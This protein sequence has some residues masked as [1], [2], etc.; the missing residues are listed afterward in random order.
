[1]NSPAEGSFAAATTANVLRGPCTVAHS[2]VCAEAIRV[3][4]ALHFLSRNGVD[5][6]AEELQRCH[7]AEALDLA[8]TRSLSN[9]L[10]APPEDAEDTPCLVE[11]RVWSS[12]RGSEVHAEGIGL[13]SSTF[14]KGDGEELAAAAE[15]SFSTP[16]VA[17]GCIEEALRI[18]L[19]TAAHLLRCSA[20]TAV[21][22][23]AAATSE[24]KG[25]G[26][27]SSFVSPSQLSAA[28]QTLP[29]LA[30]AL[31]V[32]RMQE[33]GWCA[34]ALVRF[35]EWL[36]AQSS[37]TS[38]RACLAHAL[39]LTEYERTDPPPQNAAALPTALLSYGNSHRA[40]C[41]LTPADHNR[42]SA[43][44]DRRHVYAKEVFIRDSLP[45]FFPWLRPQQN[46]GSGSVHWEKDDCTCCH[47]WFLEDLPR[48][49]VRVSLD[50][51]AIMWHR[52]RVLRNALLRWC[53]RRGLRVVAYLA[54]ASEHQTDVLEGVG[55][56]LRRE[57]GNQEH[58]EGRPAPSTATLQ[59]VSPAP[60]RRTAK[61]QTVQVEN[62]PTTHQSTAATRQSEGAP[63]RS[64]P[65]PEESDA[66]V[67]VTTTTAAPPLQKGVE[68]QVNAPAPPAA[69]SSERAQVET[70]SQSTTYEVS[71]L[72]RVLQPHNNGKMRDPKEVQHDDCDEAYRTD[73]AV[74]YDPHP[75]LLVDHAEQSSFATPP[76]PLSASVWEP[77]HDTP[78]SALT[79]ST[80]M[81]ESA[82][83]TML[84]ELPEEGKQAQEAQHTAA[85]LQ[86]HNRSRL[87]YAFF[88][89]RD[90]RLYE[91]MATR[92][93]QNQQKAH[94]VR[95]CWSMWRHRCAA[96]SQRRKEA[97]DVALSDVLTEQKA[98]E[99]FRRLIQ[100]WRR[101]ALAQR[102][103]TRTLGSRSFRLWRCE[104]RLMQY[105]RT[106]KQT[107]VGA[108]RVKREVWQRWCDRRMETAADK[109]RASSL[110]KRT[111]TAMQS[112]WEERRTL[113]AA[114][115]YYGNA[116]MVQVWH[117][118][119]SRRSHASELRLISHSVKH[120]ENLRRRSWE[121]WR[122]RMLQREQ[123]RRHESEGY[124]FY[125][126]QKL[127]H[128]FHT[129]VCRYRLE[130]RVRDLVRRHLRAFFLKPAFEKWRLRAEVCGVVRRG[131]EELAW[132]VGEQLKAR[133]VLRVWHRRAIAHA[134]GRKAARAAAAEDEACRLARLHRLA[135]TFY[136]WRT[137]GFLLRRL[138]VDRRRCL[139]AAQRT[140]PL[141]I[142]GNTCA[143]PLTATVRSSV[144]KG[145][146][147]AEQAM[148]TFF[149]AISPPPLPLP[150][151]RSDSSSA[152]RNPSTRVSPR[153]ARSTTAPTSK[154]HVHPSG[155][156]PSQRFT[157]A[158][159]E[160]SPDLRSSSAMAQQQMLL[161]K[162]NS[163]RVAN[164]QAASPHAALA[165]RS[166][167]V[168]I[169]R[170]P[171]SNSRRRTLTLE[172][173]LFAAQ[174][175]SSLSSFGIRLPLELA[176]LTPASTTILRSTLDPSRASTA[177]KQRKLS[178]L[179]PAVHA[180]SSVRS[181]TGGSRGR[182]RHS[183]SPR[184][185]PPPSPSSV[186]SR[187]RSEE[188]SE[189]DA[190]LPIRS[191]TATP[192]FPRQKTQYRSPKALPR[193]S[194]SA[195]DLVES[196][197]DPSPHQL[198]STSVGGGP[199]RESRLRSNFAPR[200]PPN[201]LLSQME[202]LLKRIRDTEADYRLPPAARPGAVWQQ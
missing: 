163:V 26:G 86:Q 91:S 51:Q 74:L 148:K 112:R 73:T 130:S 96:A 71:L 129:W 150:P 37:S 172:R 191:R 85:V 193:T 131:Q 115:K 88:H 114:V 187:T 136:H 123:R 33:P 178:L 65:L 106:S 44:Q 83:E 69:T 77:R 62:E 50:H 25:K 12:H 87:R 155:R 197:P 18:S 182:L 35:T 199:Y 41:L 180:H 29:R 14:I 139:P 143:P 42:T 79:C 128:C 113:R 127:H 137:R 78:A 145:R 192:L 13:S 101:A 166:R 57:N 99:Y 153:A 146:S 6:L 151:H 147:G 185:S 40:R 135:R 49:C 144:S 30:R 11:R 110:L 167:A 119:K 15:T 7:C 54:H 61:C 198:N 160:V 90:R 63:T 103:K 105:Q 189:I 9:R 194:S 183:S 161:E 82:T 138:L 53:T 39:S 19:C 32:L 109:W 92:Y 118:W 162:E 170:E 93:I 46:V 70:K 66:S 201:R 16:A 56:D 177:A 175:H 31:E 97:R 165:G 23:L 20:W 196:P 200:T 174:N 48:W 24:E 173:Q 75:L 95:Q 188:V 169:V 176:G 76:L 47:R 8:S 181:W 125:I 149:T 64:V 186:R 55:S 126:L 141:Q 17:R 2:A 4:F 132:R 21:S 142:Y 102:F 159:P 60:G 134:V 59:A 108:P 179:S 89:W 121:F 58:K 158:P 117:V 107:F 152:S 157:S 111:F 154:A 67:I 28:S 120:V 94:T 98:V 3:I 100:V 116:L 133:K 80:A 202:L 5:R 68:Q 81:N 156:S 164:P 45:L 43:P 27:S 140:A 10:A 190:E 171:A 184:S 1:M 72:D 122:W 38:T 104:A 22:L 168:V 84:P 195:K 52:S 36:L 34:T 124:R